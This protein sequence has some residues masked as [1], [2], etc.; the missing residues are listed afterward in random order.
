M[1]KCTNS[2]GAWCDLELSAS[3]FTGSDFTGSDF[4]GSDFTGSDFI[5]RHS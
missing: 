1:C 5:I 4:T 2:F 3:D